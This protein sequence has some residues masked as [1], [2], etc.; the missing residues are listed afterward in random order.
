M[1]SFKFGQIEV[2]SKDSHKQN[3]LTDIFMID[4]NKVVV[5]DR[6]PHN[7][8]KDW[9]YIAGYQVDGEAFLPLLIKTPKNILSYGVSQYD[10]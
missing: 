8:R 10:N 4:V 9:R 5:S 6:A 1:P 3:Q 7:N 2:E